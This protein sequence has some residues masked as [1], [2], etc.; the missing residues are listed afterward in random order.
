MSDS[1]R[2][3]STN[4][5]TGVIGHLATVPCDI[6]NNYN[7]WDDYLVS[8]S[9]RDVAKRALN[10]RRCEAAANLRVRKYTECLNEWQRSLTAAAE[11][12]NIRTASSGPHDRSVG[13]AHTLNDIPSLDKTRLVKR[14]NR[15]R[16][17]PASLLNFNDISVIPVSSGGWEPRIPIFRVD[18]EL[19]KLK[20]DYLRHLVKDRIA[21]GLVSEGLREVDLKLIEGMSA[22]NAYLAL[23]D[24]Y[25]PKS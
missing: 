6:Y 4:S 16:P 21:F 5:V 19:A 10:E 13:S 25:G 22:R 18:P 14:N 2:T 9:S 17:S 8:K 20:L 15:P 23:K 12:G 11:D 24:R 1:S 3:S 7:A